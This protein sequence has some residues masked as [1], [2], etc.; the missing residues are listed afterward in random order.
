MKKFFLMAAAVLILSVGSVY[1]TF[2]PRE[3]EKTEEDFE[4]K[5]V[6]G[7]AQLGDESEWRSASS[8]S[9]K[10]AARRHGVELMFE[11]AQQKQENQIK[12]IRSFIAHRVDVIAFS[13]VVETG[14]DNILLEAKEAGIPVVLVDRRIRTEN[15]GLYVTY[16]GSDF[17]EEGRKAGRWLTDNFPGD[18]DARI[19]ELRG[20]DGS[21]PARERAAGFR[22]AI[23]G[24][25]RFKIVRSLTAD[26]MR[27]KGREAMETILS[28]YHSPP[29]R[30]ID[31]LF[32]HNDD[33]AMGAIESMEER[34]L[35][36]G[37]DVIVI[38]VDAQKS[39]LAALKQGRMNCVVECTPYVGDQLM[40]TAKSLASGGEVPPWIYSEEAVFTRS[41]AEAELLPER[42]Y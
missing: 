29:E 12:A 2:G 15:D 26:F 25:G 34:G 30:S 14:W 37:T 11:N 38:S 17:V 3:E 7:F 36:P 32:A 23:S 40:E 39:A 1:F 24:D 21:S 42:A 13:P 8:T 5:I 18:G 16:I 28:D 27:S 9:I 33:M 35:T 4:S 41:D 20:T 22:E 6:L 31:V 19:V 10:S